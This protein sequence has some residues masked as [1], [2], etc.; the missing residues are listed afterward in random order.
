MFTG[1]HCNDL[2]YVLRLV[3]GPYAGQAAVVVECESRGYRFA[4]NG[5]YRGLFQMGSSERAKYGH[6]DTA[7][8]QAVAAYRYFVASGR[9]WSPWQCRPSGGLAW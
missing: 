9:D 3:F 1:S 2:D 7:Y 6:G 4:G 5:Q 8:E